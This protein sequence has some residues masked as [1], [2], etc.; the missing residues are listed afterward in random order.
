MSEQIQGT[1][2]FRVS[3][4][5]C[6]GCAGKINSTLQK[7]PRVNSAMVDFVTGTGLVSG[8]MSE[9][10]ASKMVRALGYGFQRARDEQQDS[11]AAP[12]P[13]VTEWPMISALI[14][15][16]PVV[17][18][19]MGPWHFSWSGEIQALLTTLFLMGPAA[20]FFRRAVSQAIHR[21]V[22]MDSLVALGMFSAWVLSV[23]LVMNGS[24]HLYFESAVMIGFF[25]LLGKK[26]ENW[27]KQH[28]LEEV[29]KLIQRRPKKAFKVV[30]SAPPEEVSIGDFKIGDHIYVRPGDMLPLDGVLLDREAGFDESIITGESQ[31]VLRKPGNLVPAGAI[32]STAFGVNLVVSRIGKDTTIEQI[33]RLVEL[34]SRSRPPVQKLADQIS[35]VFV[36]SVI[37][38]SLLTI[39][40]WRLLVKASWI[41]SLVTALSVLVVAC[42]CALGL[43]TP[44]AWIAGLGRAARSGILV[45]SYEA[46][47][48]LSKVNA[49][50]FDKTGT[51]TNGQPEVLRVL[52]DQGSVF[53]S[54]R[55]FSEE[56]LSGLDLLFSALV[57]SSHPN[58]RSI[59]TWLKRQLD[60]RRIPNSKLIAE[61]PGQGAECEC[62]VG[63]F[64]HVIKYGRPEFVAVQPQSFLLNKQDPTR[65]IVAASIDGLPRFFFELG[66]A[67]RED[68]LTCLQE[69]LNRNY[70]IYIASGDRESVIRHL[71]AKV[72]LISIESEEPRPFGHVIYQAE[73][74]PLAKNN[75]V[76][77]LQKSAG[78]V[79][80]IGDGINDAPALAA[81]DVAVAMGSGSDL[82]AGQSGLVLRSRRVMA[83]V[84]AIDLSKQTTKIIRQ[85]FFW[86][87]AYNAAAVPIAML[88]L[89]SPMWAAGAMAMSSLSVV[90]NALRLRR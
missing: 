51:L 6:G 62:K 24:T 45:R 16:L 59:S 42:P 71:F 37:C 50:V 11:S 27:A 25:V 58:A 22:T 53:T 73:M 76:L 79:A 2:K 54:T 56:D 30:E 57:H 34:S 63:D 69:L 67:L 20:D 15:A 90:L 81:A 3:G 9:D 5:T 19:A 35:L 8:S 75:L 23:V 52:N 68:A 85:N 44:V 86:A 31:P 82:A 41:D 78:K 72:P 70:K 43:A 74:T 21:H 28:S 10:D 26:L 39:I 13:N 36:P 47:E 29:E 7:D 32:N 40:S 49:I 64:K 12:G 87:F 55:H 33:I 89:M 46:L 60:G 66:D 17:I 65:S 38:L 61:V 88:G 48:I 77:S 4:M 1:I 14:L 84:E 83:L 80:F 18:I